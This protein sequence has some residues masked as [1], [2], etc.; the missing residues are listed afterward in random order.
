MSMISI[1][2][3]PVGNKRLLRIFSTRKEQQEQLSPTKNHVEPK[4]HKEIKF[5][6]SSKRQ[7]KCTSICFCVRQW[8]AQ[9]IL[10]LQQSFW[11]QV[12]VH[13]VRN[14]LGH[15]V[16]LKLYESVA[17]AASCLQ[18]K[19][20]RELKRCFDTLMASA[21]TEF[22]ETTKSTRFSPKLAR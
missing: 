2:E 22:C 20:E 8:T 10:T 1:K 13:R 4:L 18:A 17:F 7:Y 21:A 15:I 3:K 12:V 19:A 11:K 9:F 5:P 14:N 6:R 16:R